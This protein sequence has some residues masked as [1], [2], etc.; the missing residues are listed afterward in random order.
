MEL[1]SR[2]KAETRQAHTMAENASFIRG[3]LRGTMN[4]ASYVQM[5][6]GFYFLY[7]TLEQ[8]L[9]KH[10]DNPYLK[11]IFHWELFRTD[12]LR[13]DLEFFNQSWDSMAEP[14]SAMQAYTGRIR[15]LSEVA[16]YLLSAHSYVRYLGDLSGGQ[17]LKK[18]ASNSLKL[19]DGFGTAFYEFQEIDDVAEFKTLYR[20]G[21][22]ALPL[23]EE[24]REEVI[25]EAIHAFHLNIDF[26]NE[27]EGNAVRSLY[28][29]LIHQFSAA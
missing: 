28:Q 29:I 9:L 6:S 2:L 11:P 17:I 1:S 10:A 19:Q 13:K 12:A 14:S 22:D 21:L 25:Q 24:Q 26:F 7:Q 23:S 8:E 3:F 16:P 27:I 4:P 5:L 15:H 20:S 18:I